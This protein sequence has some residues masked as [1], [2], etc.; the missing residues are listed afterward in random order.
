MF[1]VLFY[2]MIGA[3]VL[4]PIAV[5]LHAIRKGRNVIKNPPSGNPV[6]GY[7]EKGNWREIPPSDK[8]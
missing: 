3:F 8:C 4:G 7:D 1:S 2:F 6:Y 5:G